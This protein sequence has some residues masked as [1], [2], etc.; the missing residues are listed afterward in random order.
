MYVQA[1]LVN[2]AI[3]IVVPRVFTKPVGIQAFDEF[4]SYLKAQQ[5]F[6][7]YSSVL[8]ALV[9]YGS[10]YWIEHGAATEAVK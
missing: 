2:A 9:L 1:L 8:L 6:I 10:N 5:A 3:V 7:V 4:V